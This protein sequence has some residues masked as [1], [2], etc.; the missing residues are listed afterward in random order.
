MF[1]NY[2]I[3]F[4]RCSTIILW[5]NLKTNCLK[6]IKVFPPSIRTYNKLPEY[7]F[8]WRT[9]TK[10]NEQL[11]DTQPT[12]ITMI[13]SI[14]NSSVLLDEF[15]V[16]I[17]TCEIFQFLISNPS[18]HQRDIFYFVISLNATGSHGWTV[19]LPVEIV[20]RDRRV[21]RTLCQ[22]STS[23]SQFR[24]RESFAVNPLNTPFRWCYRVCQTI[25][26][27]HRNAITIYALL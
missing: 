11:N 20:F 17:S 22:P 25:R 19:K 2:R 23:A 24:S 6:V 5:N 10:I 18:H 3:M 26:S 7:V 8:D 9:V 4:L 27:L 14:E 15:F 12:I 16:K 1:W 21:C 13:D